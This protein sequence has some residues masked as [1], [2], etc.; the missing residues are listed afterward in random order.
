MRRDHACPYC[1]SV[2]GQKSGLTAHFNTVH[3]KIPRLRAS[4]AK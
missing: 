3:L 2:F 4:R 1:P